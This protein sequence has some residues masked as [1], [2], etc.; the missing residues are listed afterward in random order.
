MRRL[1]AAIA[2]TVLLGCYA[3]HAGR[4]PTRPVRIIVPQAP[5]GGADTVARVITPY[6]SKALHQKF[7]V[8][9]HPG[10]SGMIGSAIVA[11]AAPDGYNFVIAGMPS[12][13]I[14]PARTSSP[15]YNPVK[16]FTYVAYV[17][18]APLVLVAN[19]ALDVKS[20]SQF[21]ARVKQRNEGLNYASTG[22]GSLTNMAADYLASKAG[23]TLRQIPYKGGSQ[24]IAAVLSGQVKAG[25][26]SLA[27]SAGFINAGA[28]VP[29]AVTSSKRIADFPNLPTFNE[30]GYHELVVTAWWAF[31]GPAGLPQSI[32][33]KLHDAVNQAIQT[34]SVRQ[35][36]EHEYMQIEALSQKQ[37]NQLIQGEIK[38]WGPIARAT[39]VPS[40]RSKK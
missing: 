17:G 12:H 18:G 27:P 23:L 37:T 20:L 1:F 11:R 28:L 14:G 15:P 31:A 26:S 29:I 24:V 6:L 16:D 9:D 8:E 36:L 35:R 32:V 3:A 38:K 39:F 33:H 2:A 7:F 30:L 34:P 13:V 22:I 19:P 10:A 4:W 21:I 40:D 5:G 25:F